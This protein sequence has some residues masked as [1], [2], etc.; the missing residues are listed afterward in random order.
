MEYKC[1]VCQQIVAGDM[2]IYTGH[3]EKHIVDLVSHDHPDWVEKDGMCKKCFEYY[4]SELKGGL[5]GDAPC[6]LRRRKV[7]GFWGA[8]YE[9]FNG[10]K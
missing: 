2:I 6:A 3:T 5:F 4:Q 1:P 8:V 9:F 7:R 10:K